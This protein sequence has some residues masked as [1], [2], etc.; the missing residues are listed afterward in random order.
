MAWV[1]LQAPIIWMFF[2]ENLL[3]GKFWN[4][5]QVEVIP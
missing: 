2:W 4:H 5:F 1:D 3:L